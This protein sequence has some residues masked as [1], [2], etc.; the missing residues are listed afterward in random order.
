VP[1]LVPLI[2]EDTGS[3]H[4][5]ISFLCYTKHTQRFRNPLQDRPYA[6]HKADWEEFATTLKEQ[7]ASNNL[8]RILEAIN[9]Q[10]DEIELSNLS[11]L[12]QL[13]EDLDHVANLL[14]QSIQEAAAKAILKARCC[15]RSKPW[16][17]KELAEQRKQVSKVIRL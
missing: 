13:Q 1:I 10:V 9:A 3:D 15:E 5:T 12:G 7:V 6:L 11:L 17:N 2:T 16:W 8:A 14:T 4:I